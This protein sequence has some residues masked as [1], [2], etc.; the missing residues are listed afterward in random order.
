MAKA[1]K[2]GVDSVDGVE[3]VLYQVPETLSPEILEKIHA[4][5]KNENVPIITADKLPEADG[6]I[7][8]IPTR[9]GSPAAQIKSFLDSTGGLWAKGALHGKPGGV[10]VSTA[11][12]G[13]GQETTGLTFLTQFVHHGM[14]FVPA[15][16]AFGEKLYNN[17]EVRG[18]SPW[19]P[20]TLAGPS[21][22]RQPSETE[23]GF[24]EHYGAVHENKRKHMLSVACVFTALA[25]V[26]SLPR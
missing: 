17:G 9:F 21:G 8:G 19:G 25:Q 23:L 24:A 26:P 14:V 13:G 12:Q 2:K 15:G 3:G 11:T 5:P 7:F 4:P 20:G 18:G 1:V 10:F 16:Y 22:E 6:L